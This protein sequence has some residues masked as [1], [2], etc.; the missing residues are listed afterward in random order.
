MTS[1]W[2]REASKLKELAGANSLVGDSIRKAVDAAAAMNDEESRMQAAAARFVDTGVKALQLS[3]AGGFPAY[4]RDY[5]RI[6][7][8]PGRLMPLEMNRAQ[9][10]M[11]ELAER[12]MA[13]RGYV[14]LIVLKGRQ[15]GASTYIAGRGYFK[16]TRKSGQ[17][18]YILTHELKA[19]NNLFKRVKDIHLHMDPRLKPATGRSNANELTFPGLASEYGV[20]TA[21]VGDT[22]RSLTV[23][24]FHGSEV[25]F[26]QAAKQIVPGLLQTIGTEPGTEVWLESTGNGPSNFF[27]ASVQE[28]RKGTT[29][30]ELVFCP[31]FWDPG[32]ATPTHLVPPNFA[33]SL[34]MDDMEYRHVHRL[35]IEQMHWRSK[36]IAEFTMSEGGDEEAGRATFCQEY[37]ATVEEAFQGDSDTSFIRSVK[38]VLARQAWSDYI[39]KNGKRP[40]G[41]GPKRMGIDP[42]YTGGDGFRL[43]CR[44]GRVAWRVDKWSRKRTQESIG[45]ILAALER[46]QPDEIYIDIG[47]NGGPIYDILSETQ[48]GSR[49]IPVLFGEAADEPDRHQN[50]RCEMWFRI[51]EWLNE[52]PQVMLEDIEEIQADLTGVHTRRDEVGT[53][54]K[55]ESKDDMIKR[56]GKGCSPD[57][58]DALALTFAYPSGGPR[59]AGAKRLDPRRQVVWGGGLR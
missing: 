55:L 51:R 22:G 20:G 30:F 58:G 49:I 59:K 33:E 25:A 39:A 15:M 24:F 11:H 57:D 40:E 36:K 53:R 18:A 21:R 3:A 17:K 48:W 10:Y 4:A 1:L 26:W 28:A 5:I 52:R 50:K 56:L 13:Q 43:W 9:L 6:R 42:S 23:Q 37:P 47:N 54:T 34:S 38:V 46:E 8:K 31:W 12:Q 44:Q 41:I 29:D 7:D 32:Y 2:Q 35:S 45:R 19:T 27:A 14:R 16:V